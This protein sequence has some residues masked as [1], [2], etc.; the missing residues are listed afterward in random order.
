MMAPEIRH[1]ALRTRVL[2]SGDCTVTRLTQQGSA[3][4]ELAQEQPGDGYI[5]MLKL[6]PPHSFEL[7]VGGER[8]GHARNAPGQSGSV[9]LVP[10]DAGVRMV[11]EAPFDMVQFDFPQR[12]LE[13]WAAA[14]G[15]PAHGPLRPPP[16][17][18]C[19]PAIAAL[20]NALLP[21]LDHPARVSP[22]FVAHATQALT[23]HLL[24]AFG[25]HAPSHVPG[26]LAPWQEQRAKERLGAHRDGPVS[27][28]AVAAECRLSPGHFA[29]AF[30]RSTG[31][32][33]TAWL[34]SQRIDSS[35]ALLRRGELSLAEIAAATGFS[36]QAHFTRAFT[37]VTGMP[38]GA[39][40]R[41][42]LVRE[43]IYR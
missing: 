18:T 29:T 41:Q 9:C 34:A 16:P 25:G 11:L 37:R 15:L 21:A 33:P 28:A 39:W 40:R 5:V 4:V 22:L 31:C 35:R 7:F 38:P 2:H 32:S 27:I 43:P 6:R 10:R 30:K 8:H 26:R 24:H 13:Q 20:G 17:G 23:A 3:H 19:D 14:H 42:Q 12:A 36:D 1:G